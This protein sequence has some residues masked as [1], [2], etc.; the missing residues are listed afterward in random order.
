[1]SEIK[2]KNSKF[3][4]ID[5]NFFKHPVTGDI[6]KKIDE[7]AV[8]TSLR[9]LVSTRF[10]D[11]KFHPEIYSQVAD[12]LFEQF[13]PTT[14]TLIERTIANLIDNFEPRVE[15]EFVD[16][17]EGSDGVTLSVKIEFKIVGTIETV[18]TQFALKRTI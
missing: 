13:T 12:L 10:F 6:S 2:T 8:I 5:L 14:K 18:Q 17:T 16:V 1:M 3:V 15:L 7:R 11:R 4:D 9:N